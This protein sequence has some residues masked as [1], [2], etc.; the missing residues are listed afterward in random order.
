M[1]IGRFTSISWLILAGSVCW[2]QSSELL[3]FDRIHKVCG[4]SRCVLRQVE[5]AGG[6]L[7]VLLTNPT[8]GIT[9]LLRISGADFRED[10]VASGADLMALAVG[11][12][13]QLA[14]IRQDRL[15]TTLSGIGDKAVHLSAPLSPGWHY[16]LFN[17][18]L[19]M[20]HRSGVFTVYPENRPVM[21]VDEARDGPVWSGVSVPTGIGALGRAN[22][23]L[24]VYDGGS[25]TRI[26][27]DLDVLP[28]PV[29]RSWR[30]AH[31]PDVQ[32][33]SGGVAI[34]SSASSPDGSK[35]YVSLSGV[36]VKEGFAI[37][38]YEAPNWKLTRS[39]VLQTPQDPIAI[40]QG[41]V[42]GYMF[43]GQV[44]AMESALF[45]V[46]TSNGLVA[47]YPLKR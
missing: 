22:G 45:V 8:N 36:P 42:D 27:L 41:N 17:G 47:R 40:R 3:S 46:D 10:V 20:F 11:T 9:N 18:S 7:Y 25:T 4:D 26:P 38:V 16:R 43:P 33:K 32:R 14:V 34:M 2:S 6:S 21:R 28:F 12:G 39:L 29:A 13:D 19:L 15:G 1:E 37:G 30:D 31:R 23:V 24:Y 44:L 5:L 35:L